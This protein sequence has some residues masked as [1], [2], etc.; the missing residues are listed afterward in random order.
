M[1]LG[2]AGRLDI[3]LDSEGVGLLLRDEDGLMISVSWTAQCPG[4]YLA[5]VAIHW[6]LLV[7]FSF[8]SS[9]QAKQA[10]RSPKITIW[11]QKRTSTMPSKLH[12]APPSTSDPA[13][14]G[15]QRQ[16]PYPAIMTGQCTPHLAQTSCMTRGRQLCLYPCTF[17]H[18][19]HTHTRLDHLT[20]VLR[21]RA[22]QYCS[23][24]TVPLPP[25]PSQAH[26]RTTGL[27]KEG[28]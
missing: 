22:D 4:I 27:T 25:P 16:L 17:S 12:D 23:P 18:A 3:S 6:V 1:L 8:L 26:P 20:P 11:L 13:T 9:G 10:S 7:P 28:Y 2:S 14:L 24:G 21:H 5:A 15:P 19:V